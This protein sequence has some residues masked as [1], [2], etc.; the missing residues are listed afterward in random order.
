MESTLLKFPSI[1]NLCGFTRS[2][3]C[4]HLTNTAKFTVNGRFSASLIH[5][6]VVEFHAEIASV[7]CTIVK[8]E[9]AD[10]L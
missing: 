3:D 5:I 1:E 2:L 8:K 6:A 9:K 10:W 4:G 7:P